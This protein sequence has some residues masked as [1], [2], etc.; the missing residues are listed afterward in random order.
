MD[1]VFGGERPI[2]AITMGDAAGVG[3]EIVVRALSDIGT[4]RVCRPLV[5]GDAGVLQAAIEGMQIKMAIHPVED[6]RDAHFQ[7]GEMDLIDLHN[8][9]LAGLRRGEVDPSAGAAAYAYIVRAAQLAMAGDVDGVVTCPICKEA[10]LLA[11]YP[12][13]GHSEIFAEKTGTKDWAMM[14]AAGTLRVVLVTAH[15]P[16]REAIA[17]I[18]AERIVRAVRLAHNAG[19][20]L[21]SSHPRIAV[22]GLNPHA[23]EGGFLGTEEAD[24]IAPAIQRARE[25]GYDAR[26]PF[27]PDTIFFR[28]VQGEFDFVTAMY[29]D[30]GLIPIKLLG[31]GEGVNVTLGLPIIRTSV[32]HGTAFDIAWR[33][34]A[35]ARSLIEAIRVAAEL[36][37]ARRR[38]EKAAST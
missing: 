37:G 23:G 5:I 14:L 12:Y 25:E 20:L 32:D 6:V 18:N 38:R 4:Y 34:R 30:Q 28:A 31:F 22:P 29:H 33:F 1:D 26:G 36:A 16:L 10:I 7:P 15:M 8:V 3:A 24:I 21:G 9:D 27:S 13:P 11:G 19:T 35:N 2:L 17:Q